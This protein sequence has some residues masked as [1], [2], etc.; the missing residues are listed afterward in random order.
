MTPG[1]ARRLGLALL[2]GAVAG[3][4]ILG[5]GGRLAMWIIALAAGQAPRFS[6]GG[7]MTVV[8]LGALFGAPG[9]AIA[10]ALRRSVAWRPLARGAVLG[11]LGLA[12]ALVV[13][14]RQFEGPVTTPPVLF[15]V[16]GSFAVMFLAYGVVLTL[17]VARW[18]ERAS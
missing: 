3:L 10:L 5:I 7:S 9:G 16:L 15:V 17:V 8:W 12:V 18:V 4:V 11:G 1:A 14:G 2:A 13:V 6:V